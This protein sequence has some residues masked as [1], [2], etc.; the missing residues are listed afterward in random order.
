MGVTELECALMQFHLR[1]SQCG[2]VTYIVNAA[3]LSLCSPSD[4]SSDERAPGVTN[5]LTGNCDGIKA[6]ASL[7]VGRSKG[8][9]MQ[10]DS[11]VRHVSW[12]GLAVSPNATPMWERV[13]NTRHRDAGHL[14][15]AK[16]QDRS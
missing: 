16:S 10:I 15:P 7:T 14:P 1:E 2:V 11:Q 4:L 6:A 5:I 3:C 12:A 13:T 9:A 8:I